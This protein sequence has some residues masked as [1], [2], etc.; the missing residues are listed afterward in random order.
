MSRQPGCPFPSPSDGGTS[1]LDNDGERL[2]LRCESIGV[3]RPPVEADEVTPSRDMT[4]ALVAFR[5]RVLDPVAASRS[6]LFRAVMDPGGG[7]SSM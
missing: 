4:A 1:K 6:A 5:F 3:S 7:R 2:L